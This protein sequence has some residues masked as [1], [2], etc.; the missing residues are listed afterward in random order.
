MSQNTDQRKETEPTPK[1]RRGRKPKTVPKKLDYTGREPIMIVKKSQKRKATEKNMAVVNIGV[2]RQE[3]A[4]MT[5]KELRIYAKAIE[6][7]LL[8]IQLNNRGSGVDR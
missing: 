8:K 2:G 3:L 1:S 7:T 5:T 6:V 4:R